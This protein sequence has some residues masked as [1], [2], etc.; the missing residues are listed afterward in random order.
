MQV[1]VIAAGRWI[2][3]LFI[4]CASR[5]DSIQAIIQELS[6]AAIAIS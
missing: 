6:C 4:R 1:E 5:M 2:A 3:A